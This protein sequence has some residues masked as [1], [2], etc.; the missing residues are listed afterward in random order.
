MDRSYHYSYKTIHE[1]DILTLV[2]Q[3]GEHTCSD[4]R[5]RIFAV[6][7]L[8]NNTQ[9]LPS[10]DL[11]YADDYE[12]GI[13]SIRVCLNIDYSLGVQETYTN[14]AI[15]CMKKQKTLR[16]LEAAVTRP[17]QV[18]GEDWPS[19]LPDWRLQP[20]TPGIILGKPPMLPD[21]Y[22]AFMS[23]VNGCTIKLQITMVRGVRVQSPASGQP[24]NISPTIVSKT[25]I[26][27][28]NSTSQLLRTA[29]N[30]YRQAA[31]CGGQDLC[32]D[33]DASDANGGLDNEVASQYITKPGCLLILNLV[34]Y[35]VNFA[36]VNDY[37]DKCSD[38]ST[39]G[40][41]WISHIT[42]GDK[43]N[44]EITLSPKVVE[45]MASCTLFTASNLGTGKYD[46]TTPMLPM[47]GL[48]PKALQT[49]DKLMVV[50]EATKPKKD[51]FIEWTGTGCNYYAL[52][53]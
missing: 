33:L 7:A 47:L 15:A 5:D 31:S 17:R 16:I 18:E 38:L 51:P 11:P 13:G 30:M 24:V 48:G 21:F 26:T 34:E 43:M 29:T 8:A 32:L 19:W 37:F 20:T 46:H 12:K 36:P 28:G 45:L 2:E 22:L 27:S 40:N 1:L 23:D 4:D 25:D 39:L 6:Y 35:L 44:S 9:R 14:F 10:I 53:F 50:A 3:F 41:E 42:N 52:V 49:G